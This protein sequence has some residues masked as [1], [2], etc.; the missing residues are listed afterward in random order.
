M[1]WYYSTVRAKLFGHV[2][3]IS[4]EA[5]GGGDKMSWS[6]RLKT[7]KGAGLPERRRRGAESDPWGSAPG[8][9]AACSPP[10]VLRCQWGPSTHAHTTHVLSH[11]F[12]IF[13]GIN[14]HTHTTQ[15]SIHMHTRT[16]TCTPIHTHTRTY[17]Y[18][19]TYAHTHM[20]THI[21]EHTHR[22]THYLQA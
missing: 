1:W 15:K 9:T 19:Y 7:T 2:T 6:W 14:L 11:M 13:S 5:R 8:G 20:H 12:Y 21:N 17:I 4:N 18:I 16:Y 22:R 10:P 3:Q